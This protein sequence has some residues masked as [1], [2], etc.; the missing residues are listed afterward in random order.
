M[1]LMFGLIF[2]FIT[3][4]IPMIIHENLL[5]LSNEYLTVQF[6]LSNGQIIS[7]NYKSQLITIKNETSLIYLNNISLDCSQLID[8]EQNINSVNFTYSCLNYELTTIYT[9]QSQWEFLEK[10]IYFTNINNETITSLQ[11]TFTILN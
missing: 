3:C 10:Q 6:N 2:S 11:T 7:L 4:I 9:L 1:H 5:E 8:Y